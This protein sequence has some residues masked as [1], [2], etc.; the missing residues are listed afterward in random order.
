MVVK[1]PRCV[2]VCVCACIL[3]YVNTPTRAHTHTHTHIVII[4]LHNVNPQRDT[5]ASEHTGVLSGTTSTDT[6][7]K[8]SLEDPLA[9]TST[10]ATS[11]GELS[12]GGEKSKLV[13][14][15]LCAVL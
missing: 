8:E 9:A 5:A 1:I 12:S 10:I 4:H 11:E 2:C 15:H 3:L 14:V 13:S 6:S 7:T